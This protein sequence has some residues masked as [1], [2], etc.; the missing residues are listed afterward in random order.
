MSLSII[1][2]P[3]F[4]GKSSELI[5]RITSSDA[6]KLVVNH[7]MDTRYAKTHIA[8]HDGK[9]IPCVCF[10]TLEQIFTNYHNQNIY[11]LDEIEEIYIDEA[12]FFSDLYDVVRD[13]V[14]NYRKNVIIS[15]LDGDFKMRPFSKSRMLEL[16]PI[17]SEILKI[18]ATC[19]KCEKPAW[20]SKRLI[21]NDEQILVGTG[22]LYQPSCLIHHKHDCN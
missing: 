19:Y 8:T 21:V 15:G 6:P 3:M 17:A 7:V 12:Q 11:Q 10:E 20:Y 16:I 9:Q 1:M 22:A 2:G 14:I 13:L 5:K 18:P 4:A